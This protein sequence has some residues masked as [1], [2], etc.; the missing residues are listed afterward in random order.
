M[1]IFLHGPP[2]SGR[3]AGGS[4]FPP[5]PAPLLVIDSETMSADS[6]ALA[7]QAALAEANRR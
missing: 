4:E 6:A 7:V 3:D 2:A 5:L 1:V